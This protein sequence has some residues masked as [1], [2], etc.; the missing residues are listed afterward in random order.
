MKLQ[1]NK[2]AADQNLSLHVLHRCLMCMWTGVQAFIERCN[3]LVTCSK[4]GYVRA[5]DLATQHCFQITL[6]QQGEVRHPVPSSPLSVIFCEMSASRSHAHLL[7]RPV[8]VLQIFLL[9]LTVLAL[10]DLVLSA[11]D[12]KEPLVPKLCRCGHWMWTQVSSSWLSVAS[13]P[14]YSCTA[15][16]TTAPA[17]LALRPESQA[18]QAARCGPAHSSH[19]WIPLTIQG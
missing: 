19:P 7:H 8:P 10:G 17:R 12:S 4:D 2:T 11:G 3:T 9:C 15:F 14:R 18:R 1:S 6:G 16:M 5:W 13:A